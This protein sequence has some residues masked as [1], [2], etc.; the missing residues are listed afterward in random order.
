MNYKQSL[1]LVAFMLCF[2]T[3]S[4]SQ[5]RNYHITNGFSIFGGMTQFDIATDNF[6]TSKE[7]GFL[8]GMW[9]TVDIPHRWYNVSF[10][11]QLSE[12]KLGILARPYRASEPSLEMESFVNYKM[13][14]AQIALLGHIK[15]G[16][17][18]VTIDLGPMFQYNSDLEM[19]D[20]S[21]GEYKISNYD[22]LNASEIASISNFNL[23]GVVGI[24]AGYKYV[25]LRAQ[26]IYG[27]TNI[28]KRLNGKVLNTEGGKSTFKGNQTMLVLGLNVSF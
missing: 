21:Q 1:L 2:V 26:Y 14:A 22:G 6:T 16:T 4:F 13:F 20:K 25:K 5:H 11:M 3:T 28:L 19:K 24:T 15:L 7:W 12:S 27:A 17:P 23:N 10:G 8:G 9:A 18:D